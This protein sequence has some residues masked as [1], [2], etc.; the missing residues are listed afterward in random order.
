MFTVR[1][2]NGQAVQ[3]NNAHCLN[4]ESSAW[5]LYTAEPSKGGEWIASIQVSA[6][7]IVESQSACRVYDARQRIE[8]EKIENLTKE[9][10]SLKRKIKGGGTG[11]K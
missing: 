6:G 5:V 8:N 4:R 1:F 10:R 7:V 3:Y 11:R 2:P 9:I